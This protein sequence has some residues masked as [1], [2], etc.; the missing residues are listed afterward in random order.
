MRR[1]GSPVVGLV[2]DAAGGGGNPASAPARIA[3][4]STAPADGKRRRVARG[5]EPRRLTNADS[6]IR[7]AA[8]PQ[9]A[10]NSSENET[11]PISL[12]FSAPDSG[13]PQAVWHL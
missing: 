7:Q 4:H 8:A 1:P 5:S 12:T 13:G 6:A 10:G 11:P 2:R 9:A 3:G